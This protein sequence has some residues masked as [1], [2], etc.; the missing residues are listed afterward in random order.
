[1]TKECVIKVRNAL[2]CGDRQIPLMIQCNNAYFC[3]E[4]NDVIKWDDD[5]ELLIAFRPNHDPQTMAKLPLL[6]SVINYELIEW[7]H[8][9]I[10]PEALDDV[11]ESVSSG[12]VSLSEDEKIA[13][14][15]N[16]I[17]ATDFFGD[18]IN[19]DRIKVSENK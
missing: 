4:K 19:K 2:R 8:A 1:M 18:K 12:I 3:W 14:R 16:L 5:N 7:I 15:N 10:T 17:A 6:V 9:R 11:T 13:I